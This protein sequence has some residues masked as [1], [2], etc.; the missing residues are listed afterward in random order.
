MKAENKYRNLKLGE[1]VETGLFL[2]P[3][4]T[5]ELSALAISGVQGRITPVSSPFAN[6]VGAAQLNSTSVDSTI[7]NVIKYFTDAGLSFGWRVGPSSTPR[8]LGKRLL[9]AGME[10]L[11]D[12]SGLY[13]DNLAVEEPEDPSLVIRKA[14]LSDLDLLVDL[15]KDAYLPHAPWGPI[16]VKAYLEPRFQS[17]NRTAVYLAF[18]SGSANPVAFGSVYYLPDQP[19]VMLS[20]AATREAYRR[21]GIYSRLVAYRLHQA[22]K[23]GAV[24]AVIQAAP[25]SAEA[26]LKLGFSKFCEIEH[27]I[28]ELA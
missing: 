12:V 6:V 10:R 28:I 15:V 11:D 13:C 4:L 7:D 5:G 19:V 24:A 16:L 21:R 25:Q 14:V 3:E 8:D 22:H 20:G 27:Y 26:C 17:E 1:A 9:A 2:L 23:L 18:E